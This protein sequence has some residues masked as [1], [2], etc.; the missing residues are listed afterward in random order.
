MDARP[1]AHVHYVAGIERLRMF[2][3][4]HFDLVYASHVLEHVPHRQTVGVLREWGRV[5]R[6]GG[7]VRLSVPDFDLLLDAYH[8][9]DADLSSIVWP[10]MGAQDYRQNFHLAVFN[11]RLLSDSLRAAGFEDIRRWAVGEDA[12]ACL[13][14]WS[15]RSMEIHGRAFPVSLNLQARW[16]GAARPS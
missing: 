1:A 2:A 12:F 7:I 16:P 13:P 14:D 8:S 4:G 11:E 10:L 6:P 15:G 3:A 9:C 5:L